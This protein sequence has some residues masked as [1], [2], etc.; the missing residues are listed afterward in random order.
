MSLNNRYLIFTYNNK[1]KFKK[2]NKLK[3]KE[4]NNL[5]NSISNLINGYNLMK[6]IICSFVKSVNII[7]NLQ[8]N[9]I[10]KDQLI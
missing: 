5:Q 7:I 6:T 4:L 8:T 9:L 3:I 1:N 2:L 10:Q